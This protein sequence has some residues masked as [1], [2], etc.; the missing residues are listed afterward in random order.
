MD[1]SFQKTLES[2]EKKLSESFNVYK[3]LKTLVEL[4]KNDLIEQKE[5]ANKI[6]ELM[7][8]YKLN[9]SEIIKL[10]INGKIFA[11]YKT[12]LM[13]KIKKPNT[14]NEFYEPHLIQ[15]L[16]E[17]DQNKKTDTLFI[18]RDSKVFH[19]ILNFLR[20]QND[21]DLPDDSE[22]LSLLQN[23]C[24]FFKLFALKDLITGD[25]P[26]IDL[27]DSIIYIF[28]KGTVYFTVYF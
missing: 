4:M 23:E 10:N 3:Q 28:N 6:A 7:K 8:E 16:L 12:T 19:H 13:K 1:K 17:N 25:K 15:V 21:F 14:E 27:Y 2:Y 20:D 26:N 18:N 22:T 9:E 5:S 24:E 11:T